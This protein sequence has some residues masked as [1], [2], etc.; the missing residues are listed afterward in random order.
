V[1]R[2]ETCLKRGGE[3]GRQGGLG[4]EGG[5]MTRTLSNPQSSMEIAAEGMIAL[6]Q[7]DGYASNSLGRGERGK[8][9][10]PPSLTSINQVNK[11]PTL[12]SA[13]V[14]MCLD[15]RDGLCETSSRASNLFF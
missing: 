6:C 10:M 2:G 7:G 14:K 9:R 11:S 1:G 13:N 8:K 12:C 3:E 5:A 4:L 15:D